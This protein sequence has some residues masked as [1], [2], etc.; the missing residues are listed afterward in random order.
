MG[1]RPARFLDEV[2]FK[3]FKQNQQVIFSELESDK[4]NYISAIISVQHRPQLHDGGRQSECDIFREFS[5]NMVNIYVHG[6]HLSRRVFRQLS[7]RGLLLRQPPPP[8]CDQFVYRQHVC[9]GPPNSPRLHPDVADRQ[10]S[11]SPLL[12]RNRPP[13]LPHVTVDHRHVD[14]R[15][16]SEPCLEL[17]GQI[18]RHLNSANVQRTHDETT[19]VL[20]DPVGVDGVVRVRLLAVLRLGKVT[21]QAQPERDLVLSSARQPLERLHLDFLLHRRHS[22]LSH[23]DRLLEDIQDGET[24]QS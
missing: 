24:P 18:S 9:R 17:L 12:F 20:E 21:E 3:F 19:R 5:Q 1:S 13:F 14:D 6:Y 7:R 2:K 22:V 8:Y 16:D 4:L 11:R 23:G 15:S 10:R